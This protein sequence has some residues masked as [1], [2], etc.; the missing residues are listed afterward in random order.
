M[1][2]TLKEFRS[3]TWPYGFKRWLWSVGLKLREIGV[4]KSGD[5]PNY[6]FEKLNPESWMPLFMEG[7]SPKNAVEFD[8][9]EG[10]EFCH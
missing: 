9:R 1:K 4:F 6:C 7:L 2:V 3:K 8:I 5:S 10:G